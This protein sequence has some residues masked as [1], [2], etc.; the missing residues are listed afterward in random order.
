[1]FVFYLDYDVLVAFI[2]LVTM[3]IGV[4]MEKTSA[5]WASLNL[6]PFKKAR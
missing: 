5:P 2:L 1:M 6:A 3:T 4:I